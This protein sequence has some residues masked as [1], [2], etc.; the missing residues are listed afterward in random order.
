M[1]VEQNGQNAHGNINEKRREARDRNFPQ[2]AKEVRGPHQPQRVFLQ[3][4]V[5]RQNKNGNYGANGGGQPGAKRP[6]IA[7]KNKE[8][9]AK[10]VENAAR[11][12]TGGGQCRVP[13]ISQVSRQRLR[14]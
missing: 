13:V 4:E 3:E 1:P 2:L 6:H 12:H 10:H 11:Q 9:I 14:K 7:S 5:G 8:V